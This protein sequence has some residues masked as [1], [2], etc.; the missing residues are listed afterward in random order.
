MDPDTWVSIGAFATLLAFATGL[1]LHTTK[2]QIAAV[3]AQIVAVEARADVRF[4]A[5]ET[6][7]DVRFEAARDHADAQFEIVRTQLSGLEKRVG[8]VE[9]DMSLVKA[10]LLGV[11]R[12][13]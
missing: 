4:A 9:D 12:A 2:A 1:I 3:K 6:H 13:G 10:H 11:I 8:A 5:V 7:A